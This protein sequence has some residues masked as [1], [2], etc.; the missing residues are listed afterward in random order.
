MILAALLWSLSRMIN[1]AV[2]YRRCRFDSH[3]NLD[4]FRKGFFGAWWL[5]TYPK[6]RFRGFL[7]ACHEGW[8]FSWGTWCQILRNFIQHSLFTLEKTCT[9]TSHRRE[10][11]LKMHAGLRSVNVHNKALFIYEFRDGVSQFTGELG[12]KSSDCKLKAMFETLTNEF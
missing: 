7:S 9:S 11:I 5:L 12:C 2:V 8:D 3:W 10:T 4:S 1:N 6:L